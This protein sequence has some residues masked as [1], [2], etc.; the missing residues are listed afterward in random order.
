M[1]TIP[2]LAILKAA[3]AAKEYS[4]QGVYIPSTTLGVSNLI[5]APTG[6]PSSRVRF[7][8]LYMSRSATGSKAPV[9]HHPPGI[10]DVSVNGWP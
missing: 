4:A 8:Y 9:L 10:M 5:L 6:T 7:E 1:N 2:G 3:T